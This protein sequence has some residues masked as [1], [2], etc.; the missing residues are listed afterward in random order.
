MTEFSLQ[1]LS[2]KVILLGFLVILLLVGL[3][4]WLP[5]AIDWS[6]TYRPA[7]QAIL[8][9]R[10]PYQMPE[11][12][13]TPFVAAP[14]GVIPLLPMAIFPEPV[15][16]VLLFVVSLAALMYAS[17]KLG[18]TPLGSG[19]FL[20]SPPVVHCLLNG[21]IEWIPI[22]GFVLPPRFGLFLVS[23]K[24]QTGFAIA[25]F[26]LYEAWV[27]GGWRRVVHIFWPISVTIAASFLLFGLWPLSST[28]AFSIAQ[29]F[30][31]SLW[32]LSIPIGLAL[33]VTSIRKRKANFAMGA[34]PFLSPYVLFHSWSGA[35]VALSPLTAE[36]V[37][38]VFGLWLVIILRAIQG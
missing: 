35:L 24:P 25:L 18:A 14:W 13:T 22:L 38:V 34:S 16:R 10:N 1:K 20:F 6:S 29:G 32:P 33:I 7:A 21:N 4:A 2:S 26:W 27:T 9:L 12:Q 30:N 36:M 3:V 11:Y 17:W 23:V 8:H 5:P 28:S 15:G 37:T 19:A 31:A